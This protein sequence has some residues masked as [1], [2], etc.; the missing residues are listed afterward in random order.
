[1]PLA[2]IAH[3]PRGESGF[4][5]PLRTIEYRANCVVLPTWH[6]CAWKWLTVIRRQDIGHELADSLYDVYRSRCSAKLIKGLEDWSVEGGL[7][8][9]QTSLQFGSSLTRFVV[10]GTR[11]RLCLVG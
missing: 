8:C 3:M 4:S 11:R 2:E 9:P 10:F 1:M 5:K 6:A 7:R